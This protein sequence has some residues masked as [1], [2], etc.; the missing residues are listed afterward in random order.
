MLS[1]AKRKWASSLANAKQKWVSIRWVHCD[2]KQIQRFDW[3]MLSRSGPVYGRL[4][5]LS[6]TSIDVFTNTIFQLQHST[7]TPNERVWRITQLAKFGFNHPS[8]VL[9]ADVFHFC[10]KCTSYTT[11]I[12]F[13]KVSAAYVSRSTIDSRYDLW[14][15]C[16]VPGMLETYLVLRL[17]YQVPDIV[18]V[19][20]HVKSV[21]AAA[22]KRCPE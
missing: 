11:D 16:T 12:L 9:T 18:L 6:T 22:P 20:C 19:L 13:Y 14:H 1:N 15:K 7:S 21:T 4:A 2:A 8:V 10:I 17:R 3:S 5:E